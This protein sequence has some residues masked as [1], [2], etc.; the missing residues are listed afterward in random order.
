[1]FSDY[2]AIYC[3]KNIENK[4][5]FLWKII[6]K[7]YLIIKQKSDATKQKNFNWIFYPTN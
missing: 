2:A 5:D 7:K 6:D 4:K 3:F 1:M